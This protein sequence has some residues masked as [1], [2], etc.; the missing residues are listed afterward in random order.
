LRAIIERLEATRIARV[1]DE[2]QPIDQRVRPASSFPS[3][4]QL[5]RHDRY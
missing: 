5:S 2:N 3:F 1:S 4:R